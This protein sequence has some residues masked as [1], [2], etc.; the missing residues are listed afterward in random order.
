MVSLKSFKLINDG[1]TDEQIDKQPGLTLDRENSRLSQ[2][3]NQQVEQQRNQLAR[4]A[5]DLNQDHT[6]EA[7]KRSAT[8]FYAATSV[9]TKHNHQERNNNTPNLSETINY[10]HLKSEEN[11]NTITNMAAPKQD[12]TDPVIVKTNDSTMIQN[13]YEGTMSSAVVEVT[14]PLNSNDP[15][16][17][18]TYNANNVAMP[19]DADNVKSGIKTLNHVPSIS[20]VVVKH[21]GTGKN[22]P[23]EI[24]GEANDNVN[25]VNDS[26]SIISNEI[27]NTSYPG[28]DAVQPTGTESLASAG[29]G[30]SSVGQIYRQ[31]LL[32][33]PSNG[34]KKHSVPPSDTTESRLSVT[35]ESDHFEIV[36]SNLSYRIEPKWYKKFNFVDRIFSHFV[37]GQTVDNHSSAT[38]TAS[39]SANMNDDQHEMH[40]S[41]HSD[42]NSN[43]PTRRKSKLDPIEIFS[44]LNGTIKSGQMTAVLGP[45]GK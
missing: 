35:T 24:G 38:S 32:A 21:E 14:L 28:D 26:S 12:D 22:A 16:I 29:S 36:W 33:Y 11:L 18:T 1:E 27:S 34:L 30:A 13:K 40:A 20:I 39:S 41:T 15:A 31:N 2:Y 9:T 45:S 19:N 17:D 37:P 4:T 7:G 44:N 42:S 5:Y 3:H 10:E 43:A 8:T 25:Y 6:T 23:V